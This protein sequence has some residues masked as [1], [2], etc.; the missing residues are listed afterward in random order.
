MNTIEF[1]KISSK[2][3]IDIKIRD[4]KDIHILLCAVNASVEF[5]LT[6]D[7]DLLELE[8]YKN[9]K[10]KTPEQFLEEIKPSCL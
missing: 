2:G 10:I 9:I 4:L 8:E 5:I 7:K 3:Q 1:T 6:N